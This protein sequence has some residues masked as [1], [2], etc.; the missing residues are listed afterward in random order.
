MARNPRLVYGRLTGWGQDGPLAHP[1]GHSLNYEALTGAIGS[2]GETDGSP[3]PLLQ[4]LGDFAGGGLHLAYGV[5]CALFEAQRSGLGQVVDTA[6]MDSRG[7]VVVQRVLRHGRVGHAHRAD[8]H[9][10]FRWGR[11]LL[12][13]VRDVGSPVRDGGADR[14]AL[15]RPAARPD[16]ESG[17]E[18]LPAQY[19]RSSWPA[20]KQRFAAVFRTKTH[21]EWQALLEG[22]DACFAPVYRFGEAH[23]HGHNVARNAFPTD[24][25]GNRQ[26]APRSQAQ[27]DPGPSPAVIRLPRGRRCR[28][29]PSLVLTRTRSPGCASRRG[30]LRRQLEDLGRLV[31]GGHRRSRRRVAACDESI[32]DPPAAVLGHR[33]EK[34][35]PGNL[36]LV[37][38]KLKTGAHACRPHSV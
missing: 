3:I 34:A 16:Q 20:M 22:T 27:P 28:R 11:P 13:R 32:R 1:A 4:V 19:D 9:Q 23:T 37:D 5:V 26:V 31:A 24:P 30:G 25:D 6:M 10:P 12:Q 7:D 8:R 38:S 29:I 15:L 36:V 14:A 21:D 2:I 18:D 33:A 17:D 35:Q